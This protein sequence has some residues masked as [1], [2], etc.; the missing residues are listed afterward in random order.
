MAV[1]QGAR[2]S[3]CFYPSPCS[4][5][6][7]LS[8]RSNYKMKLAIYTLLVFLALVNETQAQLIRSRAKPINWCD[9]APV[10]QTGPTFAAFRWAYGEF[11]SGIEGYVRSLY[12]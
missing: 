9:G 11:K 2:S 10:K 5:L 3:F 8:L 12:A 7:D 1:A 4:V 6:N